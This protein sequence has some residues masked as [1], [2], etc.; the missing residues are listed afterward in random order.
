MQ[1]PELAAVLI[2]RS[3][4]ERRPPEQPFTLASGKQSW[5]YFECQRTTSHAPAL[6][7]IGEAFYARLDASVQAVGGLTRGAD[8]IADAIAFYSA[9]EGRRPIDTFS[10]RKQLKNHGTMSWIEG[11]WEPGRRVALV[12]DVITTGGSVV[13][14]AQRC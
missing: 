14:A 2:D 4:R 13:A 9:L 7:L 10:V 5:H 11:S 6:P 8:P 3:Y 1:H 12:D